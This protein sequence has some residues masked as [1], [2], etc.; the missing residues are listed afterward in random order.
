MEP[1]YDAIPMNEPTARV[2]VYEPCDCEKCTN[3]RWFNCPTIGR[4]FIAAY[5]CPRRYVDRLGTPHPESVT[6]IYVMHLGK[7]LV[8]LD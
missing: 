2:E 7:Q 5:D 6:A 3:G 1:D 8:Y 4:R